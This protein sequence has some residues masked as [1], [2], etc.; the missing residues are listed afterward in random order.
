MHSC[1][2]TKAKS[3][4]KEIWSI[5]FEKTGCLDVCQAYTISIE[6]NGQFEYKGNYNVKHL[7]PRTGVLSTEELTELNRSLDTIDW[8]DVES[9]YGNNGEQ[10]KVIGYHT[11]TIH[12]KISYY[13]GEPQSIKNLERCIDTIIDKDEL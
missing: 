8:E 4:K 1:S 9:A 11:K 5:E 6:S 2:V 7:G 12:K 13:S 10:L 3:E